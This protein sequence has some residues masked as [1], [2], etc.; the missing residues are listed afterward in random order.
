MHLL[1]KETT[2]GTNF[3]GQFERTT[4]EREGMYLEGKMEGKAV[5]RKSLE[6]ASTF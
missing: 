3:G 1:K 5:L 6:T 2:A 4:Q